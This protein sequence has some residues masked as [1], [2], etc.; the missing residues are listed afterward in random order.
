MIIIFIDFSTRSEKKY[1][2]KLDFAGCD[3]DDFL[4][5]TLTY[6]RRRFWRNVFCLVGIDG[7][8]YEAQK[9]KQEEKTILIINGAGGV[10]RKYR[11]ATQLARKKKEKNPFREK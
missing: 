9:K 7:D 11:I 6:L 8:D 1:L 3:D 4:W 2:E 5:L 10:S